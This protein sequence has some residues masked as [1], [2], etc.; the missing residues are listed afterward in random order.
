MMLRYSFHMEDTARRIELAVDRAIEKGVR[1]ADIAAPGD[2]VVGTK[3]MASAII[4][5]L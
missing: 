3:E 4:E 2:I 1:T 5:G